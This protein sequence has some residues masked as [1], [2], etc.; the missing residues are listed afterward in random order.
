MFNLKKVFE[1]EK[2]IIAM[3]HLFPLPDDPNYDEKLGIEHI[4][5]HA[6]KEIEILQNNGVHGLLISNEFSYPYSQ[7]IS[8][9]TVASMARIIGELRKNIKVP[10]GVDCMYDAF[11]TI[12]LAIATSANFYRITLNPSSACDY[13]LGRTQLGDYIRYANRKN[14]KDAKCL[15]NIDP[16]LNLAIKSNNIDKLFNSVLIQANPDT[17]CISSKLITY[18]VV[19]NLELL[20]SIRDNTLLFCDGGCNKDN[21]KDIFMFSDGA[22]VGTTLKKD[23]EIQ[24]E[25]DESRLKEFMSCIN[26]I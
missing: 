20:S 7:N 5:N 15:I 10:F 26:N 11:S 19:E 18:L 25:V 16:S 2:P 8:Q 24:N 14:L 1:T 22:I 12:D 21:I 17:L 4:I 13:E 6:K 23:G 9:I 3:C